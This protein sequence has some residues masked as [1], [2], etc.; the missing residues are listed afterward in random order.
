MRK[1]KAVV[2]LS[3]GL[4]STT[5]LYLAQHKGYRCYCLIF[6]YGQRHKRE[7]QSAVKIAKLSNCEYKIIKF[8]LP[9]AMKSSLISK[10]IPI[11]DRDI[12]EKSNATIP[13]T[14]VPARNTIFLSFAASYAES[15]NAGTIFIGANAV[16]F[17]GYPDCRP[18]Y[19]SAFNRLIKVGTKRGAEGKRIKAVAPLLNKSKAEIVALAYK[20][21]VPLELT[22]SCY[23][24]GKKPCRRCDSCKLRE[25]GFKEAKMRDPL[26]YTPKLK[27]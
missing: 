16:D 17:S 19:F 2:L 27:K 6:D 21:G 11:P 23:E 8:S 25:K 13:S 26:V 22:W 3:G 7:I 12:T 15:I 18:T 24:G 10:K 14:Y 5:T 4:D 9:W 20:L 1:K